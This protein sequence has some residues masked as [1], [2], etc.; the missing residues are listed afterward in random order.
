VKWHKLESKWCVVWWLRR[1]NLVVMEMETE[2]V[3]HPAGYEMGM[4][5]NMGE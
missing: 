4:L 2:G 3:E 1:P 5:S